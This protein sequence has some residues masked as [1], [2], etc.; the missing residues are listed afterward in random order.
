[1]RARRQ[2]PGE[3]S[4]GSRVTCWPSYKAAEL[5]SRE[6]APERGAVHAPA[7]EIHVVDPARLANVGERI[8]GEHHEVGALPRSESAGVLEGE[9]FGRSARSGYDRLRRRHSRANHFFELTL[10]GVAEQ[11]ILEPRVGP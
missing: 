8:A 7:G 11:V 4:E 1:M 10:L 2:P 3:R 6:P 5:L 9:I